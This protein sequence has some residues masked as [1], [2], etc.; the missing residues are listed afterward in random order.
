[1]YIMVLPPI[2]HSNYMQSTL[3]ICTL[4]LFYLVQSLYL[5]RFYLMREKLLPTIPLFL[6]VVI[7]L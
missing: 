6:S 2:V 4:H 1:M 7:C 3:T 5:F